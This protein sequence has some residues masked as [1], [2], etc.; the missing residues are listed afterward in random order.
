MVGR[1]VDPCRGPVKRCLS[2]AGLDRGFRLL[3]FGDFHEP[4]DA[5]GSRHEQMLTNLQALH[6]ALKVQRAAGGNC[7]G[8]GAQGPD[9]APAILRWGHHLRRGV[10]TKEAKRPSATERARGGAPCRLGHRPRPEQARSV[11]FHFQPVD[12]LLF[13]SVAGPVVEKKHAV[14][15]RQLA[16]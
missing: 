6:R 16:D 11:A 2:A 10:V 13:E 5:D 14:A 9:D 1:N 4:L 8:T 3:D 7:V 12:L 15:G